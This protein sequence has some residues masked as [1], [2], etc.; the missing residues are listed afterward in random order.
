[1]PPTTLTATTPL[2]KNSPAYKIRTMAGDIEALK[3]GTSPVGISVAFEPIKQSA[4]EI[5]KIEIKKPAFPSRPSLQTQLSP[6]PPAGEPRSLGGPL[7][8]KIP[9]LP[10]LE[11][12][13]PQIT[14]PSRL[15]MFSPPIPSPTMP[16]PTP[17]PQKEIFNITAPA[18]KKI[19]PPS[20]QNNMPQAGE[21]SPRS[22]GEAG[23]SLSGPPATLPTLPRPTP[24]PPLPPL[25]PLPPRPAMPMP[26]RPITPP[27]SGGPPTPEPF[28]TAPPARETPFSFPTAQPRPLSTPPPITA[29][30]VPQLPPLPSLKNSSRSSGNKKLIILG[31]LAV[32]VLIFIIGEIWW[33]FLKPGPPAPSPANQAE[34]LPPPQELQPLLPPE[35]SISTTLLEKNLPEGLLSYDRVEIINVDSLTPE[36]IAMAISGFDK[37]SVG[38]E[39]I[40]RLVIKSN[41]AID[42]GAETDNLAV[43]DDV[44]GG[45]KIKI[46][47][48]VKKELLEDFDL[49]IFGSSPFDE[50]T[51]RAS[52]NSAP[53]CFG[54]RLGLVLK[55]IDSQAIVSAVKLW[56]KTMAADLKS[57]VLAKTS[58][59]TPTFQ[60]GTYKGAAI[61]YKNLPITAITIE[62]AVVGDRLIISTSK[63]S[64]LKAIDALPSETT[65]NE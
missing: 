33:F 40:V 22:L 45:L 20:P 13:R 16:M 25:P 12:L 7:A 39:E 4:P 55:T 47:T 9:A 3:K 63:T 50:Q 52:K 18:P 57:L 17:M 37:T 38:E 43:F 44:V 64:I 26:F 61:R 51:C 27:P 6:E 23:R 65:T 59:G 10:P 15:P 41:G 34:I 42:T 54:P 1:M 2:E 29:G 5:G 56:E 31:G 60:T 30:G 58:G 46:P 11:P 32:L 21:P 28:R 53:S 8:Q 19:E 48:S 36:D 35:G 62:Y 24:P 49:F 14:P